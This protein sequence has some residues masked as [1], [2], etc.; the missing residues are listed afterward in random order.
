MGKILKVACIGA[1]FFSQFHYAAWRRIG[2]VELVGSVDRDIDVAR[3]TGLPAY[4]SA[5]ALISEQMPELV[6]IITPLATHLDYIRK[7]VDAGVK[8]VICQKPFCDNREN[9]L[10]AVELAKKHNVLIVVHENFR[11]QPWYREIKSCLARGRIGKVLQLTFRL[12]PGDGQGTDAY[13]SRQPYFQKMPRFLVH[14]TAIHF[15]DVFRFLLGEPESVFSDLRRVNPVIAGED[16]G[17][18]LFSFPDNVRAL[19]DGNR[20]LDHNAEDKRCTMGEA[21]IEGTAG[22]ITLN[23]DGSVRLREFGSRKDEVIFGAQQW[24]GF[25]GDCVYN[26]QAHVV[27]ALNNNGVLENTAAEYIRNMHLEEIVY[28]SAEGGR[29]ID[30]RI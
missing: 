13:L 3:K 29:R 12:R 28:E 9:A 1:G 2:Q 18:I 25:G 11:F 5:D 7:F 8:A 30:C 16:A 19:F 22:S 15:I 17:Y 10:E 24:S 20:L 27:S 21:L 6:D 23:G 14:E 26:L 4:A